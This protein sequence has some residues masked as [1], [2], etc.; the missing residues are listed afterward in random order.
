MMTM[1][2]ITTHF[3]FRQVGEA[4]KARQVG[5]VFESVAPRYDLM[6]DVMSGG[7]HRLWK[8]FTIELSGVKAG[9]KVDRKSVV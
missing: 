7:L 1:D 4:D 2:K 8:R 9:A 3:G 5:A 6:N